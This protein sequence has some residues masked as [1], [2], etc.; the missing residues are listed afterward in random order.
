MEYDNN[1]VIFGIKDSGELVDP[2]LTEQEADY[3]LVYERLGRSHK[4]CQCFLTIFYFSL[5]EN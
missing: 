2:R 4:M 1:Q 3:Y 5:F